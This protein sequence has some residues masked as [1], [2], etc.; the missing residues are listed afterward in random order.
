[1]VATAV[2]GTPALLGDG[3]YGTLVPPADPDAL[4]AAIEALLRDPA[5]RAAVA[6]RARARVCAEFSTEAMVEGYESLYY[7]EPVEQPAR[8]EALCAV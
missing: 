6:A 8:A 1:V 4:A 3:E 5:R 2:G 7:G